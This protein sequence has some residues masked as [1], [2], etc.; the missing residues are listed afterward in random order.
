M[1][2]FQPRQFEVPELNSKF[3]VKCYYSSQKGNNKAVSVLRKELLQMKKKVLKVL[4]H[5]CTT[6]HNFNSSS[7]YII[8]VDSE[9]H[10]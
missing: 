1:L 7:Q 10:N 3:F 9:F 8:H 5:K 6:P 2:N 4:I